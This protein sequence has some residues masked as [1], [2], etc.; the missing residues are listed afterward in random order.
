VS[1]GMNFGGFTSCGVVENLTVK[2][3]LFRVM[4]I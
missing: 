3:V 1:F 4:A 2:S